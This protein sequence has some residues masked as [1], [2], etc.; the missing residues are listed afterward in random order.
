M[1]V[2]NWEGWCGLRTDIVRVFTR[3]FVDQTL[4]HAEFINQTA[5]DGNAAYDWADLAANDGATDISTKLRAVALA[6]G[7]TKRAVDERK[8]PTPGRNELASALA[9]LPQCASRNAPAASAAVQAASMSTDSFG[10][11]RDCLASDM[12]VEVSTTKSAFDQGQ[13][14][15]ITLH[16]NNKSSSAC[17]VATNPCV[18][19]VFVDDTQGNRV[20]ESNATKPCTPASETVFQP[21]KPHDLFFVWHQESCTVNACSGAAVP[22]GNYS[23]HARLPLVGGTNAGVGSAQ[24]TINAVS[25][26]TQPTPTPTRSVRRSA[27]P[28]ASASPSPSPSPSI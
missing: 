12:T 11:I 13:P 4:T 28:S 9:A 16:A 3:Y 8:D 23:T 27:S 17:Q 6:V 5:A 19:N 25:T 22:A 21:E 15:L 14:I 24:F 18:A 2:A 20:W 1:S 10:P 26:A 7:H